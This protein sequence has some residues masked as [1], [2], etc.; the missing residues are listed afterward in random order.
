MIFRRV[1]FV[2][3]FWAVLVGSSVW[4]FMQL[5]STRAAQDYKDNG[6]HSKCACLEDDPRTS[7]DKSFTAIKN[8]DNRTFCGT[9]LNG[10]RVGCP[11]SCCKP[12]CT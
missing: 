2:V 7:S 8:S 12:K 1:I 10:F 11:S 9:V 5:R 3:L 4:L 6:C